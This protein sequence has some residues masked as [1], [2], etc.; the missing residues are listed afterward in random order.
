MISSWQA[1][2]LLESWLSAQIAVNVHTNI[3]PQGFMCDKHSYPMHNRIADHG[4]GEK[5]GGLQ[6][7]H[8]AHINVHIETKRHNLQYQVID[9]MHLHQKVFWVDE[10]RGTLLLRIGA[11]G[12]FHLTQENT[13]SLQCNSK[14]SLSTHT[15]TARMMATP[16]KLKLNSPQTQTF[17]SCPVRTPTNSPQEHRSG[18]NGHIGLTYE[19]GKLEMVT[20]G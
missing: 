7:S 15:S 5:L 12:N 19:G 11:N 3:C 13:N 16:T 6:G 1:K 17:V 9:L 18:S 4:E 14:S 8:Y 10:F 2:S 20:N